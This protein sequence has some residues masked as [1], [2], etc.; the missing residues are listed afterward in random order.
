MAGE[1]RTKERGPRLNIAITDDDQNRINRLSTLLDGAT[2][3]DVVK[4][5][6]K[7]NEFV[8]DRIKE[9]ATV[10]VIAADGHETI[11]AVL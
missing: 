7:M 10:K 6:L 11:L 5:S 9:G 1:T 4:R 2:M 8:M 3:T